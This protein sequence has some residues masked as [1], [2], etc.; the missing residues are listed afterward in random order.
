[1]PQGEF[2]NNVYAG[3]GLYTFP[4]GSCYEG[5]FVDSQMHGTGTFTDA[6]VRGCI[7]EEWVLGAGVDWVDHILCRPA[8]RAAQGIPWRGQ[9]YNGTGPGLPGSATVVAT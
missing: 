4:D 9:F 5:P 2:E 3:F 7:G 1:M 6:Q 8:R